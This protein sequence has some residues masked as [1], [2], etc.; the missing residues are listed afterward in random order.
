MSGV[1]G[2][3]G[4]GTADDASKM[5]SHAGVVGTGRDHTQW[6]IHAAG[7]ANVAHEIVRNGRLLALC[8]HPFVQ[9]G[10]H[11]V[12]SI[13]D[14]AELLFQDLAK[15]GRAALQSL[16][17]DFALAFA[18][19]SGDYLLLA[20]DRMGTRNVVYAATENLVVFGPDCDTVGCHSGVSLEVDPQ[21]IYNYLYFH[22]VPGPATVYRS[23]RRIPRAHCLEVRRGEIALHRYW[24]MPFDERH[25]ATFADLRA[26]FRDVLDV[27]VATYDRPGS[28]GAFLSG[29][30]DSSTISGLLARREKRDVPAFSIGFDAS[31][32][33]E[34]EYA[35][36]AAG[37]FGLTHHTYYV[38]PV[39]VVSVVP[40]IAAAYDQPFGN[41]SAVPTYFCAD[42][43]RQHGIS[44]LLAGDGG[45]ELFGG[46]ARYARQQQFA[47]YDRIPASL[48]RSLLLAAR[49][50]PTN[51]PSLLRKA[52]SYVEQASMPMP[53]RYESYNLLERMGPASIFTDEFLA[54]VDPNQPLAHQRDV[55]R[56]TDAVSLINRMLSFD[57]QFTLADNDLPKVT[58]MCELAG[59]DVA[60][61]MLDEGVVAFSATLAPDM[62]L[63]GRKL[64]P[65]FKGALADFLPPAVIAK[66]K[67]G[68]GLPFGVWLTKDSK[69]R[70][71]AGDSLSSL[72]TRGFVRPQLID[73]LLNRDVNAHPG[74][75]GSM[76]WILM[77]LEQWHQRGRPR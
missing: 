26:R 57:F 72:T 20:I 11:R 28:T 31:G 19:P 23:L 42:L 6:M 4:K 56:D 5:S 50:L 59:V 62:K 66:T 32:Y 74:Y 15:T 16:G 13:R 76:V 35:Q 77:M 44:L 69:L 61:P 21:Q 51:T 46:N 68:F 25:S 29:G 30:T 39:D 53:D 65:F 1:F 71:L 73:Q 41:A 38:T 47:Y 75:Y 14:V 2:F 60:F 34:I 70:D 24:R 12:T 63:R 49:G 52:R 17:G 67:H 3:A 43:A 18:D 37:H 33:D 22:V 48:R 55:Y 54:S 8:G 9:Q 40:R 36:I 10:G 58:R 64:R 7:G 27:A 45:D